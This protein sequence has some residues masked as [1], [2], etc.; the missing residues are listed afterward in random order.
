MEA[1]A[2]GAR[3]TCPAPCFISA[4]RFGGCPHIAPSHLSGCK[5]T[6]PAS[7]WRRYPRAPWFCGS[8]SFF[9]TWGSFVILHLINVIAWH[10][11]EFSLKYC[12]LAILK[13]VKNHWA[14]SSAWVKNPGFGLGF[15]WGWL[16]R[17]EWDGP[18]G[19][20]LWQ[21]LWIGIRARGLWL[22]R[23]HRR[24]DDVFVCQ[25]KEHTREI[26]CSFKKR[27]G[28]KCILFGLQRNTSSH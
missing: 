2:S 28:M 5:G 11:G 12:Q 17:R 1:D 26:C 7:P 8:G 20:P 4:A 16:V 25:R 21:R 15:Q 6:S 3:R 19:L 14:A 27:S 23:A 18:A 9:Y 10:S 24:A 13:W 22:D